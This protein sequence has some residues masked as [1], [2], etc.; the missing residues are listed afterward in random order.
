LYTDIAATSAVTIDRLRATGRR[1]EARS[2]SIALAV[3]LVLNAG[4][5]WLF[6]RFH[7]LGASSRRPVARRRSMVTAEVAAMSV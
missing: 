4:W 7:K 3:N 5:S 2:Y 1:D 6:F